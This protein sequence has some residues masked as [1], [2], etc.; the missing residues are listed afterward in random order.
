M[1]LATAHLS[2]DE[3]F[4]VV[5]TAVAE[6]VKRITITHPEFPS[7]N[8]SPQDQA[9]L[10]EQG[11][12]LEHCLASILFK[13]YSWALV[14]KN[15]RYTG[16]KQ[17]YFASDLGQPGQPRIEDGLAIAADKALEAGFSQAEVQTMFV[18]NTRRLVG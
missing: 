1:I 14:F 3:I 5:A 9:A 12:F 18:E 6:G 2:R 17:V 16:I 11:A 8:L 15:I 7:Q 4:A 10:A 13:K